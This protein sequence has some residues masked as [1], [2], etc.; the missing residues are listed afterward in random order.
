MVGFLSVS[1][2][3]QLRSAIAEVTEVCNISRS[4]NR[5][6]RCEYTLSPSI[7]CVQQMHIYVCT[8]DEYFIEYLSTHS[9]MKSDNRRV[10]IVRCHSNGF[11]SY[12]NIVTIVSIKIS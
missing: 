5:N 1:S 7:T 10:N 6:L 4:R 3:L 9:N 11:N 12:G 2:H 8:C